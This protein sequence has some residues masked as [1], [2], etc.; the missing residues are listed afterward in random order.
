MSQ[1]TIH[2]RCIVQLCEAERDVVGSL[3][4]QSLAAAA[5]VTALHVFL[6]PPQQGR[7]QKL[8]LVSRAGLHDSHKVAVSL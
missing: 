6:S 5:P 4:Q 1:C 7:Q 2:S 3:L 8:L